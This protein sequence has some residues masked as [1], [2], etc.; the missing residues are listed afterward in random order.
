MRIDWAILAN[1]AEVA[2]NNLSYV[3]GA[4]WDTS[5]RPSF[6]NIF[7]GA[8]L[9]RVLFNRTEVGRAHSFEVQVLDEDGNAVAPP[10]SGQVQG[11]VP[12]DYPKGWDLPVTAAI[13]INGLPIP[14]AG[15]Y[16]FEILVDGQHLRSVP[17][18]F[19]QGSPGGGA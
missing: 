17:F 14:R 12:N 3:L 7:I 16:S 2:P 6:P 10:I 5:W 1:S 4:G 18:R 11:Q 19:L 9:L 15:F 8:L 13:G